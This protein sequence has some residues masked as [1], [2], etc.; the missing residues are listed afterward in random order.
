KR[1]WKRRAFSTS[2]G[3]L[4]GARSRTSPSRKSSRS[5]RAGS[6][7]ASLRN[8]FA[9]TLAS[10]TARAISGV[11]HPPDE[12]CTVPSRRRLGRQLLHDPERFD[13]VFSVF[14]LHDFVDVFSVD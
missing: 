2:E 4:L 9:T 6:E 8:H 1:A 3:R 11:S 12:G 5:R 14:P 10:A 13:S 7:S